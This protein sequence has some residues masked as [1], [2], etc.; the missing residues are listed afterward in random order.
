[1][2]LISKP[3]CKLLKKTLKQCIYMIYAT[4][5]KIS[6]LSKA[7]NCKSIYPNALFLTQLNK[8]TWLQHLFLKTVPN[9][10]PT[11]GW[12]IREELTILWWSSVGLYVSIRERK[13]MK[14]VQEICHQGMLVTKW[15]IMN[16]STTCEIESMKSQVYP[17]DRNYHFL[18]T[19]TIGT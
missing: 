12:I 17:N 7:S 13:L 11:L 6:Y 16:A 8:L 9:D 18:E 19:R 3:T 10:R 4:Q 15:G 1:M 5:I 2:N 14:G